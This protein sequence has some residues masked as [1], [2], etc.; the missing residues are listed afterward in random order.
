MCS[1]W[2]IKVTGSK[3]RLLARVAKHL[4]DSSQGEESLKVRINSIVGEASP[5][6][7]PASIRR[8]YTDGYKALDNFDRLW[9]EMT[10]LDH[11]HDWKSYFTWS[12]IHCAVINARAV[13]SAKIGRRVPLRDFLAEVVQESEGTVAIS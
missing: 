12:L 4:H 11:P 7:A 6:G 5:L 10:F 13:W 2:N 1:L 9:Y 8:F 3:Q